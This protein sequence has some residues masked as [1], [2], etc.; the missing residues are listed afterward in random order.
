MKITFGI[1]I[2]FSLLMGC[3][4]ASKVTAGNDLDGQWVLAVFPYQKKTL[5]EVFG[6]RVVQLQ[7]DKSSNRIFGTTGCNRFT[8][9]YTVSTDSLRFSQNLA[10]TKMACPG[11]DEQLVLQAFNRV[12][13]YRLIESQLELMQNN[14][15]VMIFARKL[16]TN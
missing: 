16:E 14:E 4:T 5:A 8:G 6:N 13:R 1:I 9:D 10:L 2:A 3:K 11:F 12:N 7:F 15:I